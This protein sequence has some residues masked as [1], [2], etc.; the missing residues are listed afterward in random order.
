MIRITHDIKKFQYAL[1]ERKKPR[2][3]KK[4]PKRKMNSGLNSTR[5]D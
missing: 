4:D 5:F 3:Y 1:F 2:Y